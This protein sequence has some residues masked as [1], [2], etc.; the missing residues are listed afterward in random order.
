MITKDDEF[1]C[2]QTCSTFDH[3][4]TSD[5]RWTER[6]GIWA[7][8]L[9]KNISF[10]TGLARYA[11]RNLM[12]GYGMVTIEDKTAHVVR[13]SRELRPEPSDLRVGPLSYEIVEPLKRVRTML[14]E[15]EYGLSFDVEF[16]ATSLPYEQ[17]PM[18]S[19][20]RGRVREDARRYYQL[21]RPSGWIKADGKT[22]EVNKET[23]RITRDHSWG[24]RMGAGGGTLPEGSFLQPPDVPEGIFYCMGIFDFE[25]WAVHFAVREDFEGRVLHFEG[26]RFNLNG[27]EGEG[28]ELQL[29]SVEH[30]LQ[31]RSD[32]RVIKSGRAILN[33]IDGSKMELSIRPILTYYP[34]PAGYDLYNDYMSGMWKGPQYIDG[35]K[36]D[37]ADPDVLKK[38]AWLTETWCEVRCGDEVGHGNFEM[39]FLGKYP[40]YGY[41]S[42]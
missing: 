4:H 28:Q 21:G 5:L 2:H 6:T 26:W 20:S 17:I 18:F 12:D 37:I 7:I 40:R 30:D 9:S 10:L 33:A 1:L 29:L 8:D 24:T 14:G 16:D 27:S 23:W 36:V 22:Y 34:G 11:N 32:I 13:V 25:K 19:R 35:F 3:A 39:F 31:F 15:N 38:V 42:Y 41:H